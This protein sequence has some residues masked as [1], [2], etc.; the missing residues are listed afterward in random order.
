M[1]SDF[2]YD[3]IPVGY[4]D[5]VYRRHRGIQSKWHHMKFNFAR[6]MIPSGKHLDLACGTGTFLGTISEFR[7]QQIGVDI[8]FPQI[9]EAKNRY[10]Q[11]GRNFLQSDINT[12]PFRE[13]T[14][15]AVSALELI[16][17]LPMHIAE[18]ALTETFRV[19]KP[20]GTLV[21]TTP[22]YKSLMR[23]IEPM[24]SWFG[25]VSYQ[26]QH[27]NKYIRSRL[28]ESLA[29]TGFVDISICG[30]LLFAPFFA[31]LG[32]SLPEKIQKLEPDW[33]TSR[34]GLLLSVC[35]KKPG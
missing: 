27:I 31:N 1:P 21:L 24:I 25:E 28:Q 9:Q 16:E 23:I 20:G 33:A 34:F 30:F 17:H 14:F 2:D 29:L 22:N 6:Q 10:G 26:D 32:W 18:N 7:S 15:D 3:T 19:L 11:A 35:A 8:S 4:Y 12:L 13:D 5:D